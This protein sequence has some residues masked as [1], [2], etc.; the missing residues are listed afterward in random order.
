MRYL[1]LLQ[2]VLRY[3]ILDYYRYD[4]K[5]SVISMKHDK[6]FVEITYSLFYDKRVFER[7]HS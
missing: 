6:N 2:L 7:K 1:P 4:N 3:I 5:K